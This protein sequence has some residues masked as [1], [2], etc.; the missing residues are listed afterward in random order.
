MRNRGKVRIAATSVAVLGGLLAGCAPAVS[1]GGFDAPDPASRLYAIRRAGRERNLDAVPHLIE[2]LNSDDPVVRMFS[3][4]ALE[5]TTGRRLGYDPYST[6]VERQ[7]AINRWV[8]A[9]K[10]DLTRTDGTNST[11][12]DGS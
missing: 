5:R 1:E 6:E 8:E 4:R 10:A 12:P 11:A 7:A 9:H 3:I 2:S